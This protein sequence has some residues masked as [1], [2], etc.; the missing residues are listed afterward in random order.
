MAIQVKS[1]IGKL[2]QVML[3]RPD[4]ELEHLVPDDL[5]RLLF[6]DIPYLKTAQNE[7]DLF[8][9]I[10]R[11]Q[12]VE[13]VYLEDLIAEVLKGNQ[14]L[15]DQFIRQFI[16]EGNV[17]DERMR[18][19]LFA[20]LNEIQDA[21]EL[22]MKLMS[23]VR[24]GELKI[25]TKR[26]LVDLIKTDSQFILDPIPNL[27]FTRDP[28]ACIGHGVSLNRMYSRTRRRETLFGKYVLENHPDF[29][30]QTPFYYKREFPYA[31]EGGDILNLS[32]QVLA[33]GISQRTTA[34]AI[35]L[36]AQNIF[37]DET[38]EIE[39]ILALDIPAV[40]AFMHLDTVCTQVDYDKF[41]IHP[42]ILGTLRIFEITKGDR[43]EE[44]QVTEM[45]TSLADILASHLH[46]DSVTLIQCGGK[47]RIASEREQWNDGS[48]TLCIEPG[49]VVVY[50]RNYVTNQILRDNGV[51][52]LEM[53]SSE[54]SRGR[55]GPR[56]MSMPL[57][58]ETIG[59]P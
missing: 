30:G 39:T 44:L 14:E 57:V 9:G 10:M 28:F 48:N 5:E 49:K 54:L 33:V 15:K 13:V 29:A 31:I 47:D 16:E 8:A 40:R 52:V 3:H 46:L 32:N 20:Y 21:K 24:A 56:C 53:A 23:G 42:G 17:V 22:V 12:G 6:D 38:S 2:R 26:P 41:T 43:K 36:L 11:G 55:G 27:Y 4:K 58:R 50:D 35:E 18:D 37:A 34:E 1:E 59:N 25:R 45:N 7:H 51:I 19:Y